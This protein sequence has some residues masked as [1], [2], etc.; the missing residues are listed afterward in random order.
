MHDGDRSDEWYRARGRLPRD[1]QLA[2]EWE[3]A[4]RRVAQKLDRLAIL[5]RDRLR[6]RYCGRVGVNLAIDHVLPISRGGGAEA[7]NLVAACK[8]CNSRKK[9]RTPQE[10]GMK[11]LEIGEAP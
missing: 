7:S 5:E 11:L 3:A 2:K 4:R 1:E 8:S 9:D 10:A 6:C